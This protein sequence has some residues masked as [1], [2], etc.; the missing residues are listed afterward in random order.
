MFS[1]F[2]SLFGTTKHIH[3]GEGKKT[4][5]TV[6]GFRHSLDYLPVCYHI[7][8]SEL[9]VT[10]LF[11]CVRI[12]PYPYSTVFSTIICVS[13]PVIKCF[14]GPKWPIN[15]L[16]RPITDQT[17]FGNMGPVPEWTWVLPDLVPLD[18]SVARAGPWQPQDRNYS[19]WV[20]S[21]FQLWKKRLWLASMWKTSCHNAHDIRLW[22]ITMRL[23]RFDRQARNG[24]RGEGQTACPVHLHL[25]CKKCQGRKSECTICNYDV[26]CFSCVLSD[27]FRQDACQTGPSWVHL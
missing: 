11:C 20:L 6:V 25:Q 21:S 8:W 2:T 4:S 5:A 27:H 26:L 22:T 9:T 18:P 16:P 1:F 17:V 7:A 19:A 14:T 23:S 12:R 13:P 3:A 24:Q 15:F 10:F